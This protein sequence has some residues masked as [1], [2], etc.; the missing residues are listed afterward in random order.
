MKV[1][2]HPREAEGKG[3]MGMAEGNGVPVCRLMRGTWDFG[4]PR[5]VLSPYTTKWQEARRAE[6]VRGWEDGLEVKT[7]ATQA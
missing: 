7:F 1:L 3:E 2:V 4:A 5:T 6:N